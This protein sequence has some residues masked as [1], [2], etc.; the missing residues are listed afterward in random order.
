[1]EKMNT[2]E[3]DIEVTE[4]SKHINHDLK[5]MDLEGAI[6]HMYDVLPAKYK[7]HSV[8]NEDEIEQSLLGNPNENSSGDDVNYSA[9]NAILLKI[10]LATL[11]PSF[12]GIK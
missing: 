5:S 7:K 3:L 2:G 1:V 10:S 8:Y 9:E 6:Y 11:T 12:I 4:I